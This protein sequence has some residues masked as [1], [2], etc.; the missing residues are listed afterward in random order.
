MSGIALLEDH[1]VRRRPLK[2]RKGREIMQFPPVDF[3]ANEIPRR[4]TLDLAPVGCV[5]RTLANS[6]LS[7]TFI[8]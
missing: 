4:T 5:R 1:F 7:T 8:S 6:V 2:M 3:G